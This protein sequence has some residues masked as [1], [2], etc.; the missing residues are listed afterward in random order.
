MAGD[1]AHDAADQGWVPPAELDGFRVVRQ[2]GRGGM[3]TVYLGHDDVLDRSVA[4]KFLAAAD[5]KTSARDRFLVE[6]RAIA[7]L[8]HPNVV[9]I[10]RVGEVFGRPYLAYELITGQSL[11]ALPKPVLWSRALELVL[12]VARGLAAA[13]RRDVLHRDIKPAN[14]MLANSGE[15]KLLD[16]GLAK[17]L[18]GSARHDEDDVEPPHRGEVIIEDML[19]GRITLA[20]GFSMP[21]ARGSF[22]R[23]AGARR[24]ERSERGERGDPAGSVERNQGLGVSAAQLAGAESSLTATGAILG[25]PRYMAPELW[26]GEPATAQSDVYALGLLLYELL[27]G[28]LPHEGLR[29]EELAE[30]VQTR[31]PRPIRSLC[32]TVPQALADVVDR[33]IRRRREERFQSALEARDALEAIRSLYQP[34][35]VVSGTPLTGIDDALQI[36][37]SFSRIAPRADEF[38]ARVYERLFVEHPELRP[39]FPAELAGQRRKLLGALVAIVDNLQR[40]EQIGPVLEDLGRRHAAYAVAPEHFDAVGA[41]LLGAIGDFDE[42]LDDQTRA[43]WGGA[44][45]NIAQAMQRGLSTERLNVSSGAIDITGAGR[46]A[47]ATRYARSGEVGLAYQVV[48]QGSIDLVLVTGWL[49]HLEAGW[50]WPPLASF[51]RSLAALGRLIVFDGRGTGLSDVGGADV[52]V[53]DRAADLRAVLDAAGAERA[54]LIGLGEG[55]ATALL[56]A[57]THPERTR[58]VVAYG[59]NARTT[60]GDG[61]PHGPSPAAQTEM[62]TRMRAS[63]GEPLFLDRLAPS[64]ANNEAFRG[65]WARYLR[66]AAGPGAAVAHYRAS[67]AIDV[68]AVLPTIRVPALVLHRGGDAAVPIAAGRA[69]AQQI[70]NASFVELAGGDHLPFV[71]DSAAIAEQV[72]RFLAQPDGPADPPPV[73]AAVVA[74]ADRG[75]SVDDDALR[76]ACEREIARFRGIEL[77]GP[78]TGRAAAMFDGPG[79]AVRFARAMLARAR[80]L[81]IELAAGVSFDT[82]WLGSANLDGV[83]GRLA[84]LVAAQAAGGE[85]VVSEGAAALLGGAFKLV[86]RG[87][88]PGEGGKIYVVRSDAT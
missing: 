24:S 15:V 37:A 69:L 31:D 52:L 39:L 58:A 63:W 83:S 7:R 1:Q 85:I 49:T 30:A 5:P 68:R 51:L 81:G 57:A 33:A 56:F 59:G 2:L 67:A 54:V 6:A 13:H 26:R 20:E 43:A 10:Y 38:C 88:L 80:A 8:Q 77:S 12:G 18:D 46:D 65:F 25:T 14:V 42:G 32:P 66:A 78:D 62:I 27:S 9:G 53:E 11:D 36:T 28:H 84:L 45:V 61:H 71:G 73:L 50:Q 23:S 34:F 75:G 86:P 44:Y 47:A 40:P 17:L 72:R 22:A 64:M 16:F 21:R 79:G 70:R 19:D 82:C 74:F 4:L 55:A 29:A 48:G 60:A 3:G 35:G 76:L 87:E 41:A